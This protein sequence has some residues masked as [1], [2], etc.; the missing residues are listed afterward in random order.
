LKIIKKIVLF[1]ILILFPLLAITSSLRIAL[2]PVFINTEYNLPGFP[3]DSYGF[4]K[5]DRLRW[6]QYSIDYL[7][8][9]VSQEEFGNTTLPDG[10]P[11]FNARE[12]S[13]M[14]DVRR[15]TA[16]VVSIWLGL[17]VFYVMMLL[18][19]LARKWGWD[20][21]K[22]LRDGAILAIFLIIVVLISV[23]LNFDLLFTKFHQIFFEGDTWLFYLSDNLIRLFP[24]RFWQ[25]LFIFIG[26]LTIIAS[27]VPIYLWHR[28]QKHAGF[29]DR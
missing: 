6:G 28:N 23:W 1:L 9:K 3:E 2:T 15:L 26:T 8:G 14:A 13:H 22:A 25:D 20:Y 11:L 27:L 10:T 4:S 24:M 18:V 16:P 19:S 29:N 21:L 7:M 5:A 12:L 17:C